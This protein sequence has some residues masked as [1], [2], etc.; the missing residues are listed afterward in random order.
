MTRKVIRTILLV[1]I[2]TY[3]AIFLY[4]RHLR[5]KANKAVDTEEEALRKLAEA[6]GSFL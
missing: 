3:T 1:S 6:K 2:G 4:Q 5:N